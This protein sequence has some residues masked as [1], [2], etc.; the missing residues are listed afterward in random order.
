MLE[1]QTDPE[2]MIEETEMISYATTVTE[3]VIS[4]EIA[5]KGKF[6]SKIIK[7]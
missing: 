3:G 6:S 4:R 2:E 7:F 5:S 1:N